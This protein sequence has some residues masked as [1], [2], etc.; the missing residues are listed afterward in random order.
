MK[1]YC[2][3]SNQNSWAKVY[4]I[5]FPVV[6]SN[7]EKSYVAYLLTIANSKKIRLHPE[8]QT[9]Q[10][11]KNGFDFQSY[12]EIRKNVKE[13]EERYVEICKIH[14]SVTLLGTILEN[15]P[16]ALVMM[17]FIFLSLDCKGIRS[18]FKNNLNNLIVDNGQENSSLVTWQEVLLFFTIT[19]IL[20]TV[21]VLKRIRYKENIAIVK[22]PTLIK[23]IFQ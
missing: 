21:F 8:H 12:S 9:G 16:Q 23:N 18:F 15:Y 17:S 3:M 1:K 14:S 4:S 19:T 13:K 22:E 2:E 7:L 11:R 5:L 6:F 10:A 20:T